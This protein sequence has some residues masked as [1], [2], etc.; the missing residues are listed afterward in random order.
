MRIDRREGQG[1][2]HAS[3]CCAVVK[4]KPANR[5]DLSPPRKPMFPAGYT[6]G[7]VPCFRESIKLWNPSVLERH[8]PSVSSDIGE[9]HRC[10]DKVW[11]SVVGACPSRTCGVSD[12]ITRSVEAVM[13]ISES[14][15][16]ALCRLPPHWM[17]S[18]LGR[19]MRKQMLCSCQSNHAVVKLTEVALAPLPASARP[20]R[21]PSPDSP[22]DNL[23][24]CDIA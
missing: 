24:V 12:C 5:P 6:N 22:C 9:R 10:D 17:E 3:I 21:L 4:P 19:W 1:N 16:H 2:D 15:W 7:R 11:S 18:M 23:D 20:Y 14:L 8:I 13:M